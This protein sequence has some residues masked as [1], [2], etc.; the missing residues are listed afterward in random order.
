MS[1]GILF[2]R[3][4]VA[5]VLAGCEGEKGDPGPAGSA[6]FRVVTGNPSVSTPSRI[7]S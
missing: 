5:V 6:T 1:R 2:I 7:N 4:G 3:V